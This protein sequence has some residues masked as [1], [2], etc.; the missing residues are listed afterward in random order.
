METAAAL[1]E[2]VLQWEWTGSTVKP[3]HRQVMMTPVVVDVSGD[4]VP[5]VVFNAFEGSRSSS[6]GVMRAVDG[7]TGAELW[8]VTDPA[9]EVRGASSIAAGDIDLDGKVELCTIPESGLGI[10][11]FEHDGTFKF[12]TSVGTNDWGGPSLAD[13]DGDGNVEILNGAHV[14]SHIGELKWVGEDG[15]NGSVGPIS[16]AADI[17]GD[18]LQELINDRAIYRH[19]GTTKCVNL[20]LQHGLAGVGNFDADGAGEIVLVAAGMVTLMDDDCT[21]LW[22]TALPGGGTGG[23]PNI[24]NFDGDPLPEIGVAGAS[25]YAVFE[26]DGTVK[27][28]SA[29]QDRNSQVTGSTTFDFEGDGAM[30][31]AYADET[32]LRIYDGA[33]GEVRFSVPNSS[34]T[35]YEFPIVVDVDADGSAELVVVSNNFGGRP[36]TAGV[37]VFRDLSDGWVST[38]RLWN[39]HAYSITNVNDNGTIPARPIANWRIPGLN[40]FRSNSQGAPPP[41]VAPDLIIT[42]VTAECAPTREQSALIATV[43]NKGGAAARANVP[44]AL[45][46]GDPAAGGVLLGVARVAVEL[47]VDQSAPARL[48]LSPLERTLEVHAVADSDGAGGSQE[49]ES[50]EDN[51]RLALT[52][53][54][55]CPAGDNVR[56][57]ALC[58]EVT[59]PADPVTCQATASVDNG[60]HDPDS[61]PQPL[62]ITE[63][64]AGPFGPGDHDITLT[65][66]DGLASAVCTALVKVR[67]VTPPTLTLVGDPAPVVQCGYALPPGVEASDSCS[68]DLTAQLE[69]VGYNPNQ[70][71]YQEVHYQVKDAAGNT[72]V[73]ATRYVTVVDDVPPRLEMMGAA[74]MEMEC[75]VD[76][77]VDPGAT[78]YDAC[79]GTLPVQKFNSGDDDGD[80]IPGSVDPDDYGPGPLGGAEGTYPVQYQA[81]DAAWNLVQLT[82]TVQTLDTLP[83]TLTLNGAESVTL[84]VGEEFVDPGASA[85]DLCYG[86]LNPSVVR[87]GNVNIHVP[88]TY[89]L[90]YT[91]EDSAGFS[92][93]PV[94]RTVTV[95]ASASAAEPSAQLP[96]VAAPKA[97]TAAPR[98]P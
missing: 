41:F 8:T 75:G 12:R 93:T 79:S 58:Q 17:D 86:D 35:T 82:R 48:Q 26:A 9:L 63:A 78:A 5:D 77:Y 31:V 72:T 49:Q 68:G 42:D 3:E 44:V 66:S 84:A 70:P 36:G 16:F 21:A 87:V 71:G 27:W 40:T 20:G 30:E 92:A 85:V 61:G 51:N 96:T 45:Y 95:A 2:P 15:G 64:P 39:Q 32:T 81:I 62:A 14:Y 22:S 74:Y 19:D 73:G 54:F 57:V 6:N 18:G 25:R 29:T 56:P 4:N 34:G 80:G 43:R 59:V 10:I 37:R 47:P 1:F 69:V 13:L 7:A 33:T 55:R 11:C 24:A 88:G 91:V 65:A 50:H 28:S 38:R 76:T 67:D 52:L 53:E 60:S 46:E 83:P 97:P 23:A 90:T 98:R 89:V 94:Q